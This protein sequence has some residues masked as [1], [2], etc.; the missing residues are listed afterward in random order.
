MAASSSS[1]T[2][3]PPPLF[4]EEGGRLDAVESLAFISSPRC[5]RGRPRRRDLERRSAVPPI[6]TVGSRVSLCVSTCVFP[7]RRSRAARRGRAR[8]YRT[9]DESLLL[10]PRPTATD[11]TVGRD[12]QQPPGCAETGA[13]GHRAR[14]LA[15]RAPAAHCGD[16]A[17]NRGRDPLTPHHD[18]S[19]RFT[20]TARTACTWTKLLRPPRR[21]YVALR[22]SGRP[23]GRRSG[24]RRGRRRAPRG[25][26]ERGWK[27]RALA[28]RRPPA[29]ARARQPA[30]WHPRSSAGA[31][32]G[33]LRALRTSNRCRA[34]WRSAPDVEGRGLLPVAGDANWPAT[35]PRLAGRHAQRGDGSA[36]PWS[37]CWTSPPHRLIWRQRRRLGIAVVPVAVRR[38][39]AT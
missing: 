36:I 22:R 1:A 5:R 25:P 11:L 6:G 29:K 33:R 10:V 23:L 17:H 13:D 24:R 39:F 35:R 28:G 37:C 15:A 18:C 16:Q 2:C 9:A 12:E 31:L 4:R 7:K 27:A 19:P 26:A 20:T 32:N 8:G 3:R 34:P 38:I 21:G 30:A 14:A